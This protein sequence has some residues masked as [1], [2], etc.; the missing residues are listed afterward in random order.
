MRTA[1]FMI[2]W[3]AATSARAEEVSVVAAPVI[4]AAPASGLDPDVARRLDDADRDAAAVAP[5]ALGPVIDRALV[6]FESSDPFSVAQR[7][8][9][10]PRTL[11]VL[12][13]IGERAR[14]AGELVIAARAFDARWTL[15]GGGHDVQLA[16]VLTTWAERD[17]DAQP[18]RALYLARRAR[19]ADPGHDRAADLDDS[20]SRNHRALTGKLAMVAGFVALAAGI[21]AYTRV[22]AIEDDLKTHPRSGADVDAALADR[23][24]YDLIGTGLL[25]AAPVISI[26]GFVWMMSGNPAYSPVSPGE[27]PALVQR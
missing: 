23:D 11:A 21:Y 3:C 18:G 20:L 16:E 9:A 12:T 24:R 13:K 10:K 5:A 15:G 25:V 22:S 1:I 26:G 4:A 27:L 8:A 19:S 6:T 17:E 2:V 7:A 14:S